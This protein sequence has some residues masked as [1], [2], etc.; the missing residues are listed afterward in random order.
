[1]NRFIKTYVYS[2]FDRY[3]NKNRT[4]NCTERKGD[5]ATTCYTIRSRHPDHDKRQKAHRRTTLHS[6]R[7]FLQELREKG[8]AEQSSKSQTGES[9]TDTECTCKLSTLSLYFYTIVYNPHFWAFLLII[10][11]SFTDELISYSIYNLSVINNITQ[12]IIGSGG[13]S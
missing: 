4:T 11:T 10:D 7:R 8:K 1:M 3:V 6:C 5:R 12:S 13:I 9:I 2:L